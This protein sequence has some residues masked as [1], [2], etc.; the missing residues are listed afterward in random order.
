MRCRQHRHVGMR[1]WWRCCWMLGQ[2]SLLK[3]GTMATHCKRHHHIVMRRWCRCCWIWG[4][5][6]VLEEASV[7]MHCKQHYSVAI[8]RWCRY[9][10][11]LERRSVGG[12]HRT[13]LQAAAL[14]DDEKWCRCCWML[15]LVG[16]KAITQQA[17]TKTAT[18]PLRSECNN[19]GDWNFTH[20]HC[21]VPGREKW[22]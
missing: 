7:A 5:R 1:R 16:T 8:R 2:R 19:F 15:E 20:Y 21:F 18:S 12:E 6:T 3:Q 22:A 14:R 13:E 10:Y 17:A 11:V 9:C 4:R